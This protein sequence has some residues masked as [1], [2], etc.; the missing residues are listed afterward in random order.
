[1]SRCHWTTSPSSG[2]KRNEDRLIGTVGSTKVICT[3]SL[4]TLPLNYPGASRS[5]PREC[6]SAAVYR[7]R[8]QLPTLSLTWKL[9]G[10]ASVL[11]GW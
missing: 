6:Q 2:V 4:K 5:W 8:H 7:V 10:R 9:F 11:K 1:M 3:E